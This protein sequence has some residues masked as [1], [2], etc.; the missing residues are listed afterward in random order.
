MNYIVIVKAWNGTF[1]L[2][3]SLEFEDS[4]GDNVLWNSKEWDEK[5]IENY[6]KDDAKKCKYTYIIKRLGD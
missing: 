3:P 1:Y 5:T 4:L 6:I 2:T